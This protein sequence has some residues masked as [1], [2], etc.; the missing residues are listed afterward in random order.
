MYVTDVVG[1][2]PYLASLFSYDVNR[3]SCIMNAVLIV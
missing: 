1:V 3:L 2:Q